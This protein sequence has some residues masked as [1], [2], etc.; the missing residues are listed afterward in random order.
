MVTNVTNAGRK[1]R[2]MSVNIINFAV[3]NIQKKNDVPKLF[4]NGGKGSADILWRANNKKISQV[5]NG[6]YIV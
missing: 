4:K 1:S 3:K 2:Q 6:K 5:Y